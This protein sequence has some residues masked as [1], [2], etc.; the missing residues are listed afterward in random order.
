MSSIPLG[1]SQRIFSAVREA[2]VYQARAHY[3]KNGHLEFVHSEVGV[4]TLRDEFE[5]VAWHN[6]RHLA[7]IEDALDR[8]VQPRPL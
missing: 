2:V 5:K 6:E 3:E 7:Q 4:R 8:G 1:V